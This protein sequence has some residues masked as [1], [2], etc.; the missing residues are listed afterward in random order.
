M[1]I[2]GVIFAEDGPA[3]TVLGLLLCYPILVFCIMVVKGKEFVGTL[4]DLMFDGSVLGFIAANIGVIAI[5]SMSLFFG[6]P[7]KL[8]GVI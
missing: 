1:K 4:F 7:L 3:P 6:I 2:I 5:G 8:L